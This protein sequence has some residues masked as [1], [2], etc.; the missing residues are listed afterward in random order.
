MNEKPILEYPCLWV[1]KIIGEDQ[2]Q[3]RKAAAEIIADLTYTASPSNSSRRGKYHCLH[4]EI[5][6]TDEKQRNMIFT[7]LK[8]HPHVRMVL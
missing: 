3:L 1:Y 2:K 5:E 8:Q 4:I 6:V 7:A